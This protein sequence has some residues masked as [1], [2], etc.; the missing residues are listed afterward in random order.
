MSFACCPRERTHLVE[1][2][3]LRLLQLPQVLDR[4]LDDLI[5]LHSH[6][7]GVLLVLG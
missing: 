3:P 6:V 1:D 5:P 4:V 7:P 2:L